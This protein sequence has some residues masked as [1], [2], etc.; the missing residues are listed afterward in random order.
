MSPAA[1]RV[2][3]ENVALVSCNGVGFFFAVEGPNW[4]GWGLEG[5]VFR[6]N[7]D[8]RNDRCDILLHAALV[9]FVLQ[10]LL[11][12]V[13]NVALTH[14]PTF[15]EWEGCALTMFCSIAHA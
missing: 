10:A 15:W 12:V 11:Q 2:F 6:I 7:N 13:A 8:L 9:Q 14:G 5:W 3:F 1:A 4:L